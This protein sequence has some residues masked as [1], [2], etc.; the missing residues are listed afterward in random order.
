MRIINPCELNK[1]L[2]SKFP[3]AYQLEETA[4]KV[5]VV[6]QSKA[7]GV[8]KQD[9]DTCPNKAVDNDNNSSPPKV[10]TRIVRLPPRDRYTL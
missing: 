7:Y 2:S 6:I 1:E 10:Q 5:R 9:K 3:Q 8:T 4:E